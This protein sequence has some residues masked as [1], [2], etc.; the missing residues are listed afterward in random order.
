MQ[1][2]AGGIGRFNRDPLAPAV[3]SF[4]MLD[5]A[6]EMVQRNQPAPTEGFQRE[7][8]LQTG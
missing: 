6:L 2:K 5:S 4:T 7:I 1:L 8:S 3:C